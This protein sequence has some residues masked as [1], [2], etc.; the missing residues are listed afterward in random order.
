[1]EK[2]TIKKNDIYTIE[3]EDLSTDGSG[4]GKVDGYTLFVKDALI[5]DTAEV[6][7][8]KTKKHYG[9]GRL[10]RI[11][12]PSPDRVEAPC[13]HARSCGGCQIQHLSYERQLAFKENKVRNL[14][15]RVGHVEDYVMHPIIGMEHPYYYRNKAQFPVGLGKDG[16]IVTGFYAGHTHVIVDSAHCCIQAPVN[17]Q[18]LV[19]VKK[20]MTDHD[21][22][23]YDETTHKG[24]VRHILTRVGFKTKEIMVCLIINGKKLPHSESLVE[25]LREIP[26]MTSISFNINQEK[27]NVILG[28][29]VVTLW[30]QDYITDYIGDVRYQISPLSFYQVNP[31]Q[32]EKLYGAVPFH[33][34]WPRKPNRSMGLKLFPRLLMMPSA[35]LQSMIYI[36]LNFMWE[37]Q[38]KYCRR[39]MNVSISMQ[40]SSWWTRR[41]RAVTRACWHVSH[42]CSQSGWSMSAAI[43]PHWPE[44]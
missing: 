7:V 9:Y 43:R 6:K 4:I 26:G 24:L 8:I 15:S 16:Q 41:E 18:L 20:W 10:M 2:K 22:A 13:P 27:T 34:L 5:G 33:F 30:G 40:T 35:M 32:T 3:I 19:I 39:L 21:I 1:M 12:T 17:E 42:R 31:V 14:L 38:K 23:P 37:R 25:A 29:K 44:I 28:S 36:M 11:I